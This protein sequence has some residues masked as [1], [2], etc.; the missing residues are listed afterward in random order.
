MLKKDVQRSTPEYF[1]Y[2]T[3]RTRKNA[4]VH[5][6]TEAKTSLP[7]NTIMSAQPIPDW[8]AFYHGTRR[9][10]S[11]QEIYLQLQMLAWDLPAVALVSKDTQKPFYQRDKLSDGQH[12]PQPFFPLAFPE[13]LPLPYAGK[14]TVLLGLDV[15][16]AGHQGPNPWMRSA[17]ARNR[18]TPNTLHSTLLTIDPVGQK[19]LQLR[20]THHAREADQTVS[21]IITGK[22]SF[23][24]ANALDFQTRVKV[25]QN[26]NLIEYVFAKDGALSGIHNSQGNTIPVGDDKTFAK[27]ALGLDGSTLNHAQTLR[28]LWMNAGRV[29]PHNPLHK[30]VALQKVPETVQVI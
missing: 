11:L 12:V 26:D 24:S 30:L 28:S 18:Q 4:R 9:E 25:V 7:W 6:A 23:V 8:K 20:T 27:Y 16:P 15:Y 14:D 3:N 2:H 19:S 13:R 22:P 17:I 21:V 10:D 5:I 29:T 1:Q